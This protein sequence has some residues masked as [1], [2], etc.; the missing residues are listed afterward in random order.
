L[1]LRLGTCC[2]VGQCQQQDNEITTLTIPYK[3]PLNITRYTV[4]TPIHTYTVDKRESC[5]STSSRC[6]RKW[7]AHPFR[8]GSSSRFPDQD[9]FR[10]SRLTR[11]MR[12]IE[13]SC[14]VERGKATEDFRQGSPSGD[15]KT[16]RG[17]LGVDGVIYGKPD[18]VIGLQEQSIVLLTLI[19][20][21]VEGLS[22]LGSASRQQ[23][24]FAL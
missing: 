3:T 11:L 6:H 9:G 19:Q 10:I 18:L 7:K 13:S 4:C 17:R 21:L 1:L 23:T 5:R 22:G 15:G 2:N 8:G 16:I 12:I 24:R 20:A 14:H